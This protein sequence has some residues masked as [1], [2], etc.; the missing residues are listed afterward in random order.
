MKDDA[1]LMKNTKEFRDGVKAAGFQTI[2]GMTPVV[3]INMY[4]IC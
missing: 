4:L 3:P 2:D 1:Q